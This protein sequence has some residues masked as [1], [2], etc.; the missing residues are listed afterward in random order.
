MRNPKRYDLE[1]HTLEFARRVRAIVK[2]KR[3]ALA[4]KATELMNVFGS[5]LHGK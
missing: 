3:K 4:L 5:I 1:D 2:K